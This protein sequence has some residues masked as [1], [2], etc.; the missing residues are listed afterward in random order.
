MKQLKGQMSLFDFLEP[1]VG[2]WVT[3]HGAVICHIMREGMI[4][5]K[6]VWDCGTESMP[7]LCKVG[8]LE[9]VLPDHYY[10]L[11]NGEY[12]RKPCDRVIIYT[13]K[14]Q[15]SSLLLMPGTEIYECLNWDKYP[16]RMASIG[17]RT[18]REA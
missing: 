1:E 13:G 6:I 17:M 5:K 14:K 4:G 8:I 16:G 15:R 18:K 11:I 2:E 9:K 3:R 7:D 10:H 12:I